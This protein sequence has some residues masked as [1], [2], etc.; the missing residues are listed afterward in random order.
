MGRRLTSTV[1]LPPAGILSLFTDKLQFVAHRLIK[2]D[3]FE[4]AQ[5]VDQAVK[6]IAAGELQLSKLMTENKQLK[7]V[8]VLDYNRVWD[9]EED[10]P[11]VMQSWKGKHDGK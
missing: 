6:K 11:D 4:A 1:Q 3:D 9:A 2:A 10:E 7:D 5:I 8:L